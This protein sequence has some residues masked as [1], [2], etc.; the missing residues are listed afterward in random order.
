MYARDQK[1][2]AA[3]A[4]QSPDNFARVVKFIYL[5]VQQ[6]LYTVGDALYSVDR[7]GARSR[8]AW[9]WKATA[10]D[11][12]DENAAEVWRIADELSLAGPEALLAYLADLPGLGLVKGGFLAQL[13]WGVAGC[14]DTHNIQRFELNP[15]EFAASRFKGLKTATKRQRL[16]R[17]YLALCQRC[18][19]PEGLWNDWC[20]YVAAITDKGN[21]R[22]PYQ[23]SGDY[24]SSLH[25]RFICG[26]MAT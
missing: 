22:G 19:G 16:V 24:V 11:W 13:C 5:T 15:R 14:I 21:S 9:G 20:D 3:F 12:I 10:I 2:I 8:Y 4:R 26:Q 7:E 25:Q 18:G 17:D 23:G 6:P 1:A